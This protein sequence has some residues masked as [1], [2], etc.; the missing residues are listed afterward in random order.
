MPG[1]AGPGDTMVSMKP[2]AYL[3]KAHSK[4]REQTVHRKVNQRIVDN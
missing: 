3:H 4:V 1:I 2:T